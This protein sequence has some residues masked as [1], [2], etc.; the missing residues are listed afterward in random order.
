[1]TNKVLIIPDIH[2][3]S[4]WNKAI[5]AINNVDKVVFLGD[6]LD[7]YPSENITNEEALEEFKKIIKFKVDNSDKVILLLGNHDC[8]YCYSNKNITRYDYTNEAVIKELF[9]KYR[10]LFQL[11]YL[12]NGILYT[13]AGVTNSWLKDIDYTID[14]LINN[15]EDYLINSLWN[16]SFMRGGQNNTGSI[17]WSDVR[18]LDREST[19]YQIFGHTQLI[20]KPIITDTYACL[21]ARKLFILNT[22]TKKIKEYES[23][24]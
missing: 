17:I 2:G 24:D 12:A 6:Y 9:N 23:L 4:F 7:P 19:Y 22:E 8:S 14:D 15:N 10:N 3:R 18:E 5:N 13:H 16:I 11:K 21:D 20:S 1:M